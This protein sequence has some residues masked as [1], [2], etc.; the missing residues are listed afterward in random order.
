MIILG[1]SYKQFTQ[2]DFDSYRNTYIGFVFED[3]NILED[4]DIEQAHSKLSTEKK[5]FFQ[6]EK[7]EYDKLDAYDFI[8]RQQL[9]IK[10]SDTEIIKSKIINHLAKNEML[11]NLRQLK[12]F[13]YESYHKNFSSYIEKH[14]EENQ[15]ELKKIL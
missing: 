10:D 2:A 14:L 6:I 15:T 9:E 5:S 7:Y 12:T 3:F 8:N 11:I 1:K 13:D 4:Y